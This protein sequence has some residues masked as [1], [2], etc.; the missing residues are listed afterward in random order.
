MQLYG[1]TLRLLH[2]LSPA[3]QMWFRCSVAWIQTAPT[4]Q[5]RPRLTVQGDLQLFLASKATYVPYDSQTPLHLHQRHRSLSLSRKNRLLAHTLHLPGALPT[6]QAPPLSY[7]LTRHDLH[8]ANCAARELRP[9]GLQLSTLHPNPHYLP[10]P[11]RN[12]LLLLRPRPRSPSLNLNRRIMP[13]PLCHP[14]TLS[15]CFASSP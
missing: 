8:L 4:T 7:L 12:P 1:H 13:P 5:D 2:R 14:S 6:H 10:S 9:S 15:T 3:W 11:T